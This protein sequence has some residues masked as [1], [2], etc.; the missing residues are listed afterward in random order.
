MYR[1]LELG[2]VD[3]AQFLMHISRQDVPSQSMVAGPTH[4]PPSTTQSHGLTELH[5]LVLYTDEPLPP[6]FTVSIF[7]K[8]FEI[9]FVGFCFEV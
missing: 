1:A 3:T 6:A 4:S 5:E 8:N 2:H 7:A 9:F